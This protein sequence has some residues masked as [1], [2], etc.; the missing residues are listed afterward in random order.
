MTA[1]AEIRKSIGNNALM[2]NGSYVFSGYNS[3]DY[4]FDASF[5]IPW[6]SIVLSLKV[7]TSL[8]KPYLTDQFYRSNHFIWENDFTQISSWQSAF[9]LDIPSRNI[10]FSYQHLSANSFVFYDASARPQQFN[11]QLTIERFEI[12]KD[13]RFGKFGL[14]VQE[15]LQLPSSEVVRVPLLSS[16]LNLFLE[17]YIFKNALKIQTGLDVFYN[18][19]YMP[20]G[21][22]APTRVFHMQHDFQ[23]KSYPFINAYLSLKVKTVRAFILVEHLNQGL[24]GEDY[25]VMPGYTGP[26]RSIRLGV[27]WSFFN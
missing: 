20:Y 2:L 21:Y 13:F 27:N 6:K 15:L 17:D 26:L 19:T 24:M 12:R 14:I 3:S 25:V 11:D 5:Q 7:Q 10:F 9:H 23:T 1:E 4:L 18:T 22:M 16:R 8:L